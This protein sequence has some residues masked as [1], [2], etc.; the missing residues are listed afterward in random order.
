MNKSILINNINVNLINQ[1]LLFVI[2]IITLPI[3][4]KL[5]GVEEFGN[6]IMLISAASMLTFSD[7][8]IS[9]ILNNLLTKKI[10]EKKYIAANKIYSNSLVLF[11]SVSGLLL[12]TIIL[13][14]SLLNKSIDIKPLILLSIATIVSCYC[15]ILSSL[16]RSLNKYSLSINIKNIFLFI[17]AII[18]IV[19][20]RYVGTAIVMALGVLLVRLAM[21]LAFRK[22]IGDMPECYYF[23]SKYINKKICTSIFIK[24]V[25]FNKFTL[26]NIL[27]FQGMTLIFG[28]KSGNAEVVI[29]SV[30]RTLMRSIIQIGSIFSNALWPIFTMQYRERSYKSLNELY[31]TSIIYICMLSFLLCILIFIYSEDILN[32]ISHGEVLYNSQLIIV[33]LIYAFIGCIGNI[34]KIFLIALDEYS[35]L[36]DLYLIISIILLSFLFIFFDKIVFYFLSLLLIEMIISIYSLFKSTKCIKHLY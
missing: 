36:A 33:G 30:Y 31:K 6:W 2:Q 10:I 11:Y 22:A 27:S 3:F 13:F 1:G 35:G 29:F 25:K 17:E 34:S 15:E 4:I 20:V 26:A 24:A 23:E 14:F 7:F 9:S 5:L 28:F 21:T 16:L 12:T 32:F 18:L 19:L 8:G